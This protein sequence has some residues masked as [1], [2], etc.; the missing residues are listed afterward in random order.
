MLQR[1]LLSLARIEEDLVTLE[2]TIRGD[3]LDPMARILV[4]VFQA[5]E[6]EKDNE[7]LYSRLSWLDIEVINR[8]LGCSAAVGSA[9]FHEMP[10]SRH[11]EP[12]FRRR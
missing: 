10:N 4:T 6:R 11:N 9:V 3:L 2:V 7:L 8:D 12:C 5:E 1:Q